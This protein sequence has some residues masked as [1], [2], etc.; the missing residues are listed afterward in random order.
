MGIPGRIRDM[1]ITS[2]NSLGGTAEK[3]IAL[4]ELLRKQGISC[5]EHRGSESASRS[6]Y[7]GS[8]RLQQQ[9]PPMR[10]RRRDLKTCGNQRVLANVG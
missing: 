3:E 9:T 2:G 10:L 8:L 7:N 1:D 4:E 6:L 5:V